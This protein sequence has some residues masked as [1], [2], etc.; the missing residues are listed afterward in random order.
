MN[1]KRGKRVGIVIGGSGLIGGTI[2]YYFKKYCDSNIQ[3][4]APNSKKMSLRNPADI[5]QYIEYY[6]P[7]FIINSAIAAIDSDP[8]MAYEVNYLGSINLAK[9]AIALKIPYIYISSAAVLANG[10]DVQ[11]HQ[12]RPL[13][14]EMSHYAKSKLMC[15]R[16]LAY[17]S[18]NEGLDYTA[19]RL[20]IVYGKH[21][22]KI[23]G[24]HR[25]LFSVADQSMPWLFTRKDVCH[26]YT[27]AK[28]I[29]PFIEHILKNRAE[30]RGEIYNFVDANQVSLP[31]LILTIKSFLELKKPINFYMPLDLAQFGAGLLARLVKMMGRLG[32]EA[33]M[34]AE[35]MFLENFYESQVL[36]A[37]KLNRSS[38]RDPFPQETVFSNLPDLIEYYLTR[39][40]QLNLISAFNKEF[41]DPAHQV[42]EFLLAP[43]SLLHKHHTGVVNPFCDFGR[44]DKG[45]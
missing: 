31:Q 14:A 32:I 3:L 34:P 17:L 40:E 28:K 39:W 29:G 22:H 16:S 1:H 23:Q 43:E 4:L 30:F 10:L 12:V 44:M 41:F 24:F 7:D 9:A 35:L 15:E 25:L 5:K 19:V 18:E 8:Q 26:S 6:R 33:R 45:Q 38:F 2:V 42:D 37:T 21:D 13:V 27:N 11:E 36:S 20:A